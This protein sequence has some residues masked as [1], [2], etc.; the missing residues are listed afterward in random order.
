VRA[1]LRPRYE[2]GC[3]R[4]L[5]SNDYYQS[6]NRPNTRLVT[7]PVTGVSADAVITADGDRHPVDTIILATG[8][9][10]HDFVAP[11]RVTGLDGQ[12]LNTV[13]RRRPRAFLGMTIP[14]FPNFFLMYGPNTNV[15]SGSIVHML[16]SQM[17]YIGEAARLVS[18]GGYLDLRPDALLRFDAAAQKRLSTTVWNTGGCHSWYLIDDP[19]GSPVNTNNW[20]GSMTGY[21]RRTRRLDPRDYH[22]VRAVQARTPGSGHVAHENWTEAVDR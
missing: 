2:F 3:K 5:T 15:G 21:R 18:G 16:E 6:L 10:S 1:A 12:D 11:M 17:N 13:W 20:P 8:F 19:D 22:V 7:S 4:I 9:R 14:G